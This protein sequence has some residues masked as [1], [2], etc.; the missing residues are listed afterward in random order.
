VQGKGG[1]VGEAVA[2]EATLSFDV[3]AE[4]VF[5]C[6]SMA[7]RFT[8]KYDQQNALTRMRFGTNDITTSRHK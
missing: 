6:R 3:E 1:D 2:D 8:G 7:I 5:T 4:E